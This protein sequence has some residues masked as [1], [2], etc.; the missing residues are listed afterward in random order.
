MLCC[1]ILPREAQKHADV[2]KVVEATRLAKEMA[3]E[4]ALDGELQL[5][6]AIV[7]EIPALPRLQIP[8]LPDMPM[9]WYSQTWMLV[10]LVISW[11]RDLAK[12]LLTVQCARVLPSQ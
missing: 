10:I 7:P 11:F 8:R 1:P 12:Q 9:Y 2:D 3:P 4:L 5:D 6:A